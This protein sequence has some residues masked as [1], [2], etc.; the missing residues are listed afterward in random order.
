MRVEQRRI[1]L[2]PPYRNPEGRRYA[3]VSRHRCWVVVDI[4]GIRDR[5]GGADRADRGPARKSP[6]LLLGDSTLG[7]FWPERVGLR[8]TSWE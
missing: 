7:R 2:M 5:A 6:V 1:M 8:S 4:S 3:V